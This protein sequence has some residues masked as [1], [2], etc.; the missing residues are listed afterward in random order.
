MRKKSERYEKLLF[1]VRT[2]EKMNMHVEK[3]CKQHDISKSDFIREIICSSL[4]SNTLDYYEWIRDKADYPGSLTQFL[5]E[6]VRSLF[7]SQGIEL[8]KVTVVHTQPQKV[9]DFE[10]KKMKK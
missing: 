6:A 7:D 4:D 3:Y 2:T 10:N 1:P 8:A 9:G 5:N